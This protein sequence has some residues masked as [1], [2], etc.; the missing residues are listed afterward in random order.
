MC[1]GREVNPA[2]EKLKQ[3]LLD[4]TASFYDP[5]AQ[6]QT[7]VAKITDYDEQRSLIKVFSDFPF[8]RFLAIGDSLSMSPMGGLRKGT[9]QAYYRGHEKDFS[10]FYLKKL[11]H[12]FSDDDYLPR[13]QQVKFNSPIL[14]QRILQ[15]DQQRRELIGQK[16]NILERLTEMNQFLWD[17]PSTIERMDSEHQKRIL[18]LERE[19]IQRKKQLTEQRILNQRERGELL[20]QL[21][22]LKV[23]IEYYRLDRPRLETDLWSMDRDLDLPMG[24]KPQTRPIE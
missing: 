6:Y 23:D 8:I 3:Q 9:C 12:C 15:A 21:H 24:R 4:G 7:F 22:T 11:S 10:L 20:K 18:E 17:F 19:H 16:K 2:D 5:S 13:G 1:F 14:K